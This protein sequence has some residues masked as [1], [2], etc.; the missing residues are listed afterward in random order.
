MNTREIASVADR[1][2]FPGHPNVRAVWT[3][4]SRIAT[5]ITHISSPLRNTTE[6]CAGDHGVMQTLDVQPW[7]HGDPR[8][9]AALRGLIRVG[10]AEAVRTRTGHHYRL[11]PPRADALAS[12]VDGVSA[13]AVRA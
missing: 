7:P 8:R 4:L 11:L 13:A 10:L 12:A 1:C 2:D 9:E 5:A 6:T 3:L